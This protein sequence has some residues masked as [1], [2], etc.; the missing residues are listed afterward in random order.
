[1]IDLGDVTLM[2]GFIDAHTHLIG[3]VLGDPAGENAAVRDFE[4]FRSDSQCAA[5]ACNVDGWFHERAQRQCGSPR[6]IDMA[7]RKAIDEGWT[8]GRRMMTGGHS[9]GITRRTL[10]RGMDLG[11]GFLIPGDR[12]R[13]R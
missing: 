13:H 3:R 7:L 4:S 2:P 6:L 9:L 5:C 10:R 8:P 12:G 11:P 1:M